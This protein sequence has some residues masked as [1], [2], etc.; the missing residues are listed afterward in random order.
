MTK[1]TR[2]KRP[3][4]LSVKPLAE[5]P[6]ITV[7]KAG[8]NKPSPLGWPYNLSWR[9]LRPFLSMILQR[10]IA[11]GRE[12][13]ARY[14]ERFSYYQDAPPTGTI[15]L[16][17]VSVG[18]TVAA[19]ALIDGL[20]ANKPHHQF[21]VTTNTVTAANLVASY[22]GKARISHLYQPL[23]HPEYVDRFL[24]ATRPIIA[25]FMESDFW[26]NLI[27][28]TASANIPVVF[29]SSQLSDK[30]F[31]RWRQRAMS[32][33][34]FGSAS[35]VLAVNQEQADRFQQLGANPDH[36][37]VGGSLKLASTGMAVDEAF[38]A[39]L[40]KVA[41]GRNI[42]LAASTHQDEDE[43]VILAAQELGAPWLTI[44]APRHPERGD[45][46]A[47]LYQQLT[48]EG[49]L[50]RRSKQQL[51]ARGDQLYLADTLGEMGSMFSSADAVFLGG[52]LRPIGG[53]NP[54]EPAQFGLPV[55]TGPHIAKNAA[56][57]AGLRA[58]GG[59]IDIADG[60][61][62]TNAVLSVPRGKRTTRARGNTQ[63]NTQSK[64]AATIAKAVKLYAKDAGKRPR[65]AADYIL[66]LLAGRI[67]S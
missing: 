7:G 62:L 3:S 61:Q 53:H 14:H 4:N 1:K 11:K 49:S 41:G 32:K 50:A 46:I 23:D 9:I 22:N 15:W 42:F 43:A 37:H 5:R 28:R 10:R 29:A 16:H 67:S 45:S 34:V 12:D 26:P 33:A 47:A 66:Q 54:L 48:G 31:S 60:G 57:F 52:S 2:P 21:L 6:V 38:C 39:A 44:I 24:A 35:L 13:A 25:I 36:T 27:T 17:A 40:A 30:A 64:Q 58:V 19:L 63:S 56:E 65:I 59:V 18:E 8:G 55:I 20:A 51:P